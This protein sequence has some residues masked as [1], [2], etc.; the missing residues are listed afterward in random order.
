MKKDSYVICVDDSNWDSRVFKLMSGLPKVNH[1]YKVRRF[2]P[3]YYTGCPEDGIA[4][5]GIDG[6]WIWYE[7]RNSKIFIEC[8]FRISRFREIDAPDHFVD[9]LLEKIDVEELAP[10]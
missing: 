9:A 4:I 10:V 3:K 8:H 2:F 7:R 6:E 1:I 5:E